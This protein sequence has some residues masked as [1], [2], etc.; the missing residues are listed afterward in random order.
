MSQDFQRSSSSQKACNTC[1]RSSSQKFMASTVPL[2]WLW[3]LRAAETRKTMN[4][5]TM[6]EWRLSFS[7]LSASDLQGSGDNTLLWG[8]LG[9]AEAVFNTLWASAWVPS[10]SFRGA[11]ELNASKS[12]RNC[13]SWGVFCRMGFMAANPVDP[14]LGSLHLQMCVISLLINCSS[15]PISSGQSTG[16]DKVRSCCHGGVRR[17]LL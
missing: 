10:S 13:R 4:D 12:W 7:T 1:C 3:G 2:R 14:P 17:C 15:S 9:G 6:V 16:S 8:G 11:K 5:E